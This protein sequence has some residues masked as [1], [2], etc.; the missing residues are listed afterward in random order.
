MTQP[1]ST[2]LA[3]TKIDMQRLL[4]GFAI[5][6]C[7]FKSLTAS[8][9]LTGCSLRLLRRY[10]YQV[11]REDEFLKDVVGLHFFFLPILKTNLPFGVLKQQLGGVSLEDLDRS[12]RPASP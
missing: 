4:L 5:F 3:T 1:L 8:C 7:I 11:F 10:V 9:F 12:T 6:R 2:N